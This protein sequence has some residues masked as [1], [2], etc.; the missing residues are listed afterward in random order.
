MIGDMPM[1]P[2]FRYR[3][4]FFKGKPRHTKMDAFYIRHPHMDLGKRAK[5]FAPFDALR[6]FS[7]AL[8][9]EEVKQDEDSDRIKIMEYEDD[10]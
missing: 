3:E 6:G 9:T 5:L 8:L 7:T 1:P 2:G 10:E 4:I